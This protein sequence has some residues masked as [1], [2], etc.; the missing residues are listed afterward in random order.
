MKNRFLRVTALMLVLVM[1]SLSFAGCASSKVYKLTDGQYG[2]YSI[3][4]D[5]YRYFLGYYKAQIVDSLSQNEGFADTASYWNQELD[6]NYSKLFGEG[7]RTYSDMY[8][9]MYRA[10]IDQAVTT[11]LLCQLLFDQYGLEDTDLWKKYSD[12][13]NSILY[14]FLTYYGLSSSALNAAGKDCGITYDLLERIYTLQAKTSC[15]QEY[16]YGTNGEKLDAAFLDEFFHGSDA[17]KSDG[18]LGYIAYSLIKDIREGAPTSTAMNIL[19]VGFF[20]L[21]A[22]GIA[23]YTT[24]L[25]LRDKKEQKQREKKEKSEALNDS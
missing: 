8:E 10:S 4:E 17:M 19:T 18:Y 11:H 22:V 16:L 20:S 2:T 9:L 3:R 6:S 24:I 7:V 13:I 23:V 5:E 14:T 12:N 15:V 1:M 25:V 21:A